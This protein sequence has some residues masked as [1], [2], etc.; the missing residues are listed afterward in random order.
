VEEDMYRVVD[1]LM[2]KVRTKADWLRVFDL[3]DIP[4]YGLYRM[5]TTGYLSSFPSAQQ[6]RF[7]F[8]SV[9]VWTVKLLHHTLHGFRLLAALATHG[10]KLFQFTFLDAEWADTLV[11]RVYQLFTC[12]IC[13]K[14]RAV[15][16]G[17]QTRPSIDET[18]I[19][20][21]KSTMKRS[22]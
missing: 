1:L 14:V 22:N 18:G 6:S 15:W 2:S 21:S 3:I 12:V 13:Q 7:P 11:A 8:P 9:G 16:E 10:I 19:L 17:V 5:D 4:T 20:S